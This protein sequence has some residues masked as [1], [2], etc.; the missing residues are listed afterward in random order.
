MES[1]YAVFEKEIEENRG[2]IEK[3]I[4]FDSQQKRKIARIYRENCSAESGVGAHSNFF[5]AQVKQHETL[6]VFVKTCGAR[7]V[8]AG[9]LILWIG[10]KRAYAEIAFSILGD[11][12]VIFFSSYCLMENQKSEKDFFANYFSRNDLR[13]SEMHSGIMVSR[14]IKWFSDQFIKQDAPKI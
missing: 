8:A 9:L 3:E 2:N 10:G 12:E 11:G 14:I 4:E 13:I 7:S 5:A 6:F 1:T